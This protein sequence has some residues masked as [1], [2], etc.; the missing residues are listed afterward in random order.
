MSADVLVDTSV[1]IS[2]FRGGD[3]GLIERINGLLRSGKAVFTGIIA[4]ELINGAKGQRELQ[5]LNDVFDVMR[6]VRVGDDTF[7]RAGRLGFELAR[8]GTTA[9]TVDLLVAQIAIENDLA[10]MTY[11][12]HFSAI[13]RHSGLVLYEQ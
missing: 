11:D 13:A 6:C 2:F 7:Q 4:L 3:N 10:L 1:W 5:I 12:A 8:K 9:G